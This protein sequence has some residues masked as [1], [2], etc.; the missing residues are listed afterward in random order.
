MNPPSMPPF[1]PY[2]LGVRHASGSMPPETPRYTLTALHSLD[3]LIMNEL[4]QCRVV[5]YLFRKVTATSKVIS[6]LLN[7]VDTSTEQQ[8]VIMSTLMYLNCS[9]RSTALNFRYICGVRKVGG[10]RTQAA[11]AAAAH[12][13]RGQVRP[14]W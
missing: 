2:S 14:A 11:E 6:P 7:L 3:I 8:S 13:G 5:V 10:R 12:G 9:P 4:T 1:T